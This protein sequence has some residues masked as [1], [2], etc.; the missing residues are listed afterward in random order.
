MRLP[1]LVLSAAIA[2][3]AALHTQHSAANGNA[4]Y[5]GSDLMNDIAASGRVDEGRADGKDVYRD[6]FALG[7]VSGATNALTYASPFVCVPPHA[8]VAQSV[9]IVKQYLTAHPEQWSEDAIVLVT[10][11]LSQAFPCSHPK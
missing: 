3:A 1:I 9:A 10:A 7:F 6:G 11:A 8:T 2:C 4:G 5:L